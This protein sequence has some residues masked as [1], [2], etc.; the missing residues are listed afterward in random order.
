MKHLRAFVAV[1]AAL[2]LVMAALTAAIATAAYAD[3]VKENAT[4]PEFTAR[5]IDGRPMRLS[6][7][8]GRVV[9]LDFG[10]VNC[11]PCRLEMPILE[12][13]HRKYR[14]RGLVVVGLM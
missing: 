1:P 8:R 14:G 2:V 7:L 3:P 10:A 4:A 9:L 6:S 5:T 11:P 12:S 13:W